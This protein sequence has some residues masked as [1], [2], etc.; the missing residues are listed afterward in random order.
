MKKMGKRKFQ[1][2]ELILSL[3]PSANLV[4]IFYQNI[5]AAV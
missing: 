5:K 2:Q 4:I 1:V 3:S